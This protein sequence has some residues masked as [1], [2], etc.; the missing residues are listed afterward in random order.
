MPYCLRAGVDISAKHCKH[1]Q[2][3]EKTCSNCRHYTVEIDIQIEV[4][5]E[6]S[7]KVRKT[8]INKEKAC[9][10]RVDPDCGYPATTKGM[11]SKC[12]QKTRYWERKHG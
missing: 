5:I 11:C 12:Y 3:V 6:P 8:A 7:I 4:E 1:I 9:N 10:S 2:E